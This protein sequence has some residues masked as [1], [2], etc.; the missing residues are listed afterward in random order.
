MKLLCGI[1]EAGRGPLAGPVYASCVVLGD[2]FPEGLLAQLNDSKKLTPKKREKLAPQI[3]EH[4]LAWGIG[5]AD[6]TEIDRINILQATLRSMERAFDAMKKMLAEKTGKELD[7]VELE[8]IIDGISAP[9]IGIPLRCEPK[10]DGNYPC[11]MAASILAKTERDAV[12][13]QYDA[14]Y[15]GYGYAGHKGYGTEKHYEAIRKLG[16]SPIQRMSFKIK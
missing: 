14:L 8:A 5:C 6:H 7:S 3:K 9:G 16:P 15:P 12:M 11:V 13:I 10:A 2:S 4:A 1:D